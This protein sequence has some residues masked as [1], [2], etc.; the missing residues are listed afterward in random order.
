MFNLRL[1]IKFCDVD[2]YSY[3]VT[4]EIFERS[5]TKNTKFFYLSFWWK[6]YQYK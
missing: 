1:K 2:K 5:L 6:S 3:A 4:P